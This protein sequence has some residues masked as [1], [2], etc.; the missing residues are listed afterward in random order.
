VHCL[1]LMFRS[2]RAIRF[3]TNAAAACSPMNFAANAAA[4]FSPT[5]QRGLNV[6]PHHPGREYGHSRFTRPEIQTV[7]RRSRV[8]LVC[9]PRAGSL[10]DR[11][12]HKVATWV[13]SYCS[14][15]SSALCQ[16]T[17]PDTFSL[18]PSLNENQTKTA[19]RN[20]PCRLFLNLGFV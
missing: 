17:V 6:F 20:S 13:S 11:P 19:D 5:L 12:K 7:V 1:R 15:F 2:R 18:T 8:D 10:R 16:Q 3:A 14:E 4:A 9:R